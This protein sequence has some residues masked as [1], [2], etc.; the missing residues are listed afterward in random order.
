MNH[1]AWQVTGIM[2]GDQA[3]FE[4]GYNIIFDNC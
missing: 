1:K 2:I 3:S 4:T